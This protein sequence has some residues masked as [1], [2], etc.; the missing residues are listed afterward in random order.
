MVSLCVTQIAIATATGF[1]AISHFTRRYTELHG[2]SRPPSTAARR[3]ARA[4]LP[5]AASAPPPEPLWIELCLP[6][7]AV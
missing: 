3:A 4:P 1:A 2:V 7:Q 5:L 6:V